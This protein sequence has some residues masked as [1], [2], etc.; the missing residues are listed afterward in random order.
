MCVAVAG[1]RAAAGSPARLLISHQEITMQYLKHRCGPGALLALCLLAACSKTPEAA[2]PGQPVQRA[3]RDSF[4]LVTEARPASLEGYFKLSR[5]AYELCVIQ[6]E[7]EKVAVRPYPP[8]PPDFVIN[9]ITTISDGKSF[10]TIE[11]NFNYPFDFKVANACSS[12]VESSV[13]T[14]VVHQGLQKN[15]DPDVP[16]EEPQEPIPVPTLPFDEENARGYTVSKTINGIA[17][18]CTDGTEPLA[19]A[20]LVIDTC[21]VDPAV[22]RIA[23]PDGEP[24]MASMRD[25]ANAAPPVN[26]E[27]VHTPLSLK[28]GLKVDPAVFT[29]AAVK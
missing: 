10:A 28:V 6:A 16:G 14:I 19:Q 9:R 24:M 8:I 12:E 11:R 15:L 29:R 13:R 2:A 20:K 17:L 18:K 21:I 23:G 26:S 22:G 25:L 4:E 5:T 3:A 27:I 1:G 7:Q